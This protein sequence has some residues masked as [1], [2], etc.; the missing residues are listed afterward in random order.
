MLQSPPMGGKRTLVVGLSQ[1]F[2]VFWFFLRVLGFDLRALHL[3]G[4]HPTTRATPPAM[5]EYQPLTHTVQGLGLGY[6]CRTKPGL[7]SA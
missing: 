6:D 4:V 3:L 1:C 5:F 7:S 2:F